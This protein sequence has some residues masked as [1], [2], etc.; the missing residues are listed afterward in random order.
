MKNSKIVNLF[1]F[2]TAPSILFKKGPKLLFSIIHNNSII[3]MPVTIQKNTTVGY[4]SNLP[5]TSYLSPITPYPTTPYLNTFT[6]STANNATASKAITDV[7]ESLLSHLT[8]QQNYDKIF[9]ILQLYSTLFDTSRPLQATTSIQHVIDTGNR[10]P[11]TTRPYF[12]TIEQRKDIQQRITNMLCACII[13][14]STSPWSSPAILLKK[15]DGSFRFLVYN[16]K[17][18]EVT[19]KDS[20][21][22]PNTE[23]L[24]Q[25]IGRHSWFTKLDLKSGYFQIPI[26]QADKEKNCVC[27]LGRPLYQF[28]VLPQGLANAP[29][30]FQRVMNNLLANNRWDWL[31]VYLDDIMVFCR[32]F[33]EHMKHLN[34]VLAILHARNFQLNPLK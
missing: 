19:K 7:I 6:H 22:Q 16:R 1:E 20:Y 21:P 3:Q 28:E 25:R 23:E 12:K 33:D 9:E 17:L 29:P 13:I 34:E 31:V 15:P 2:S 14:P 26:Q 30:T 18:N 8:L 32:S 11:V 5:S 24:L 10:L 4:L 27:H